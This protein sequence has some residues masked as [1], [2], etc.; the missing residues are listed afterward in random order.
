MAN[1]SDT[2]DGLFTCWCGAKGTFDQLFDDEPFL[3]GGCGGTG[4]LHCE[5]GGSICVCHHHGEV[6]CPGC[7]D[8][9]LYDEGWESEEYHDDD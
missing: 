8:C 2:D 7:S 3:S 5:C 4:V 9:D 1:E 6:Q